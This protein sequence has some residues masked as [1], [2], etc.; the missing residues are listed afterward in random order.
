MLCRDTDKAATPALSVTDITKVDFDRDT[1]TL[2]LDVSYQVANGSADEGEIRIY[3]NNLAQVGDAVE[4]EDDAQTGHVPATGTERFELTLQPAQF[5][6]FSAAFSAKQT[7]TA[8]AANR[9][10]QPKVLRQG[11]GSIFVGFLDLAARDLDGNWVPDTGEDDPGA[12][13]HFNVDNDDNSNNLVPNPPAPVFTPPIINAGKYPGADYAQDQVAGE[14]DDVKQALVTIAPLPTTGKVRLVR[15]SSILR[16]WHAWNKGQA[17]LDFDANNRKTWNLADEEERGDFRLEWKDSLYV[18]GYQDGT[19]TLEL[20]L[21]DAEDNVLAHDSVTY[22]FI[23]ADCGNQPTSNDLTYWIGTALYSQRGYYEQLNPNLRRCEWSMIGP[24]STAYNCMAYAVDDVNHFYN[25]AMIHGFWGGPGTTL[26]QDVVRFFADQDL[27][28][29]RQRP[30][31]PQFRLLQGEEATLENA[32]V[33]Y[34][35]GFH[36]AKKRNCGC[37]LGKWDNLMFAGKDAQF[38]V[39]EHIWN[40]IS[41]GQPRFLFQRQ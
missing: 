12:Y 35:S 17:M 18:E 34:Y 26:E 14:E 37:G 1:L 30:W 2:T 5:G 11:V 16:A 24:S 7:A 38:D 29:N 15:G 4:I 31:G 23:D 22:N 6:L 25:Q 20:Q 19:T 39:M 13:V 41:A 27:Q 10:G 36:A 33:I 28:L 9:D 32:D 21:L 40:Q 8:G 3:D